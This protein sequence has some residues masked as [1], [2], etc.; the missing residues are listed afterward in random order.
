V[1]VQAGGHPY[2]L[3][4]HADSLYLTDWEAHTVSRLPLPPSNDTAPALLQTGIDYVMD[5]LA[6]SSAPAPA[7][8]SP[9]HDHSCAALC[10]PRGGLPA[11]ACPSH[12]TLA[13]DGESCTGPASF[14]LFSQKNKISRLL[15]DPGQPDEVPDMVLPIKRARSIQAVAYDPLEE[16]IYWVDHGRGE[17]P[18]RQVIRRARDTGG[19][20][21]VQLFDR[22]DRFLPYDLVINPYSQTLY[23]TCANTNTINATRLGAVLVPLGPVLVGGPADQPRLLA[24]HPGRQT[25]YV[26]MAG[27]YT[28]EEAEGGRIEAVSLLTGERRVLVQTSVGAVTALTVD[29]EEPEGEL[30]WAD[31]VLKRLEAAGPDGTRRLVVSEGVVEPVGLAVLGRWLYWA[32]RDQARVTRVDK[33]AG[34]D[35]QIVLSRVP[36]LSSLTAVPRLDTAALR[37][38]PC[39]SGDG[40]CSH[41]CAALPAG[42]LH[43]SCPLGL[44]IGA[45]NRT[46]GS[47]PTCSATEFTCLTAAAGPACIP[48]QWRCDGQSECADRSDELDCPECGPNQFRCQSSQCVPSVK[49]CDGTPDCDDRTDEQQCCGTAEFQCAVTGECVGRGKLCDG[50]HDCGDSS[51]ELLPRCSALAAGGGRPSA[52]CCPDHSARQLGSQAATVN[53]STYLIIVFAGVIS[54]FVVSLA[55]LYCRRRAGLRGERVGDSEARRPLAPLQPGGEQVAPERGR[56]VGAEPAGPVAGSSNGLLYDRSHVT[57]ASSTGGTSSSGCGRGAQGPPPSPATSIG[58]KLS[59]LGPSSHRS[60]SLGR[61][62]SKHSFVAGLPTGYRFYTHR[63][64]PP[65]TPCSTDVADESDYMTGPAHPYPGRPHFPSRAGSTAPSRTG[66]DSETYREEDLPGGELPSLSERGRYAPPPTTPLYLSDYCCED[67]DS[68]RA[69]SPTEG[70]FFLN[71]CLPGPPPSPVPGPGHR[72]MED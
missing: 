56:A 72:E 44:L 60:K 36:R 42:G 62:T 33:A 7:P 52:P 34:T 29:T 31:I 50:Q 27:E 53:T 65:C 47:P 39:F 38:D 1:T 40:A 70:S 23:W 24:I 58:T 69:P 6:Y 46:C 66:Y 35:R 55:V 21:R 5:L 59:R 8:A 45:D 37:R 57:G 28:G 32:D 9:C 20:D 54:L 17:Q 48:L 71:R 41:F 63:A 64:A 43:C 14:L 19:I 18:A 25:L 26:S 3:T 16:M 13:E 51:D 30:Y 22:A 11:G 49:L 15:L 67:G 4:V 10:I 2:A 61:P 12:Y 68:S